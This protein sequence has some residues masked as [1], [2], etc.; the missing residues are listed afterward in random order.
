M[1]I[2]PDGDAVGS[3]LSLV[4]A[5]NQMDIKSFVIA[6]NSVPGNLHWM[7]NFNRIYV[8][9]PVS[10]VQEIC[11]N[12][13]LIISVDFNYYS[14]V[15]KYAALLEECNKPSVLIDHHAKPVQ[16]VDLLISNIN[17][18]CTCEIIFELLKLSKFQLTVDI[19][20]CIYVGIIT[21][22]GIFSYSSSN[23]KTFE[24][25]IE[26]LRLGI[27]KD[28]ITNL[29]YKSL[30]VEQIKLLGHIIHQQMIIMSD[31]PVGYI[32]MTLKDQFKFNYQPGYSENFVNYPLSIEKVRFSA[33]F[34]ENKKFIRVSF[35]SKGDFDV[36]EF[37]K[38]YFNG[39][40]HK[41]A[42]G[43]KRFE[44]LQA[45]IE[46]FEKLVIQYANQI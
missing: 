5:F 30:P 1:H 16:K 40:G 18:S 39:G 11:N 29:V 17:V 34:V 46:D 6:P 13:D 44:S 26:L 27:D 20:S 23:I 36:N 28:K 4:A 19:A 22:T 41:N 32:Y 10:E 14:R 37:A 35:R 42:A 7:P 9:L 24:S 31:F 25:V 33:F 8:N 3:A 43:G 15:E 38:K 2:N 21:D 12:S 45:V